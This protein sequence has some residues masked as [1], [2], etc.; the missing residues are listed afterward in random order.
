MKNPFCIQPGVLICKIK[1][2]VSIQYLIRNVFSRM[3]LPAKFPPGVISFPEF[4]DLFN[5]I[6]EMKR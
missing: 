6:F 1:N 2:Q 3:L 5:G 4:Q